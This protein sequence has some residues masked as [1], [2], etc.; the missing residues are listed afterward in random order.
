MDGTH[1]FDGDA[2]VL[3]SREIDDLLLHLRGLALVRNLLTERGATR[4]E[5]DAHTAELERLRGRLAD[6][7]RGSAGSEPSGSLGEAA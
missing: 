2:A 4:A 1:R 7:I 5:L 6:A 3:L